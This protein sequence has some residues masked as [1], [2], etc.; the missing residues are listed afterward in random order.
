MSLGSV[1]FAEINLLNMDF[2]QECFRRTFAAKNR[3]HL[4][5]LN[6]PAPHHPVISKV[7]EIQDT[8]WTHWLVQDNPILT[9]TRK[10][11]IYNVLKKSPYLLA[12]DWEGKRV[13]P[14][15]VIYSMFD[16]SYHVVDQ[17]KGQ[18]VE[19]F[20]TADGGQSDAT[21]CHCNIVVNFEGKFR[22]VQV[23]SYYHSGK[24]TG[25]TKAMSVYAKELKVFKE[26]CE[27]KYKMN[28][29]EFMVDP[30]CKSLREELHLLGIKTKGAMNNNGE[31]KGSSQ[32]IE[33]GIERLQNAMSDERY[34]LLENNTYHHNGILTEIGM[35]VRLDNGKP[36]DNYNHALDSA[37]YAINYFYKRYVN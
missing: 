33:V 23:A 19:M 21:T 11:E 1:F 28:H 34:Y 37:R 26:W 24:D 10:L 8:K 32:G 14:S 17:L 12:R 13:M 5:D 27:R 18:P 35:Y 4:A 15:G 31:V 25:E 9:E 6:P 29:T 2:I 3:F 22:M 30:A 16:T 20:F 7:F 36:I